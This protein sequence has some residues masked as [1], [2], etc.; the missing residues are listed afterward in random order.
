M[1]GWMDRIH[2]FGA[3]RH[4][5]VADRVARVDRRDAAAGGFLGEDD[6]V[7]CELVRFR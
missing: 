4:A 6:V 2:L 5:R 3:A 1:R 7:G